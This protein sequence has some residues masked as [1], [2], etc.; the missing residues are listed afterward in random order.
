MDPVAADRRWDGGGHRLDDGAV[1]L[2]VADGTDPG[3]DAGTGSPPAATG[4]AGGGF[5]DAATT[6]DARRHAM[7]S[8]S[9]QCL[10]F[11]SKP[12]FGEGLGIN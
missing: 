12:S 11:T 7:A 4:H 2:P 5:R 6:S 3:G 8:A 10:A 9:D 1:A